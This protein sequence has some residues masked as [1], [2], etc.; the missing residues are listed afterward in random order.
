MGFETVNKFEKKIWEEKRKI[1]DFYPIIFTRK[2]VE[3]SRL[4]QGTVLL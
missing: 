1:S 2:L 4:M 3:R